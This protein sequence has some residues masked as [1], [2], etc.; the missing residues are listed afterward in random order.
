[1][2]V[3]RIFAT[4]FEDWQALLRAMHEAGAE[5]RE[6]KLDSPPRIQRRSTLRYVRSDG[7]N[8]ARVKVVVAE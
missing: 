6:G 4:D 2:M 8:P 3:E 5:F 7:P 1:M